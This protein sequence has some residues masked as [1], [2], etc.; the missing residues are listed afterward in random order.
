MQYPLQVSKRPWQNIKVLSKFGMVMES[1]G[2]CCKHSSQHAYSYKNVVSRKKIILPIVIA[3]FFPPFLILWQGNANAITFGT[4]T[5]TV[6]HAFFF[7]KYYQFCI[8][9]WEI[10]KI[11]SFDRVETFWTS[12]L[13]HFQCYRKV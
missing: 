10:L 4:G 5:K 11:W 6:P 7:S 12:I 9:N 13:E 8:M 2:K 1:V 3:P